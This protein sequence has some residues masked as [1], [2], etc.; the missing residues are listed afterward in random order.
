MHRTK[1][2]MGYLH[3]DPLDDL[4]GDLHNRLDD[5]VDGLGNL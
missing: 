4:P 1:G 2:T 3:R 5:L